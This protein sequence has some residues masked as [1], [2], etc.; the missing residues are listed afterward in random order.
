MPTL[1]VLATTSFSHCLFTVIIYDCDFH[2]S[3]LHLSE[4]NSI[5]NIN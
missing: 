3:H 1:L 4:T 2:T 5:T